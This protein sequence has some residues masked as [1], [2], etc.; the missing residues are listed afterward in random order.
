[1]GWWVAAGRVQ[2]G[3]GRTIARNTAGYYEKYSGLLREILIVI[4][5][6]VPVESGFGRSLCERRGLEVRRP[7]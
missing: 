2:V 7:R 5:R 1:M 3:T 4:V 6:G